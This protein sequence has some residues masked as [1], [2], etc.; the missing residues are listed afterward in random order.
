MKF[1]EERAEIF[2]AMHQFR[3]NVKQP[4]KTAENPFFKNKY[5]VLEG[6]VKAIDEAIKGTG[7]SYVQEA[8]SGQSEVSVKT[9][10]L[11]ESGQYIELEPLSVPVTKEDAQAFGSARTYACRYALSTAFG[12]TS[13]EDDDGNSASGDN[14]PKNYRNPK[15]ASAKQKTMMNALIK[16]V[17]TKNNMSIG[18]VTNK[19]AAE[20][21]VSNLQ[22]ITSQQASSMI[23]KLKEMA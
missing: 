3:M 22:N 18:E 17:S 8:T 1:S 14:A 10:I 5:V 19:V 7:L 6:V 11:H 20:C 23:T 21:K 16:E 2:K 9:V 12:I 13:E 4:K 15:V